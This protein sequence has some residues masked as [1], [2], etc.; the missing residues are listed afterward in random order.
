MIDCLNLP[1]NLKI[2]IYSDGH[3]RI[4]GVNSGGALFGCQNLVQNVYR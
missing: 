4:A 2:K 3:F 1:K